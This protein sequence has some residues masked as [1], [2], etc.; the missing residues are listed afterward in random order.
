MKLSKAFIILP[1]FI[2]NLAS[3]SETIADKN[4]SVGSSFEFS[5]EVR[6]EVEK[7]LMQATVFSRKTGKSLAD[8]R[9]SVS[10]NLNQT[11]ESVKQYSTI[12]LESGGIRNVVN[13]SNN[14]KIDGWITEGRIHLKS[15]DFEAMAKV[16]ENLSS[17]MA[18][19][20]IYFSVSPEKIASLEDEMTLEIIKQFQHKADVI[21]K[22]LKLDKY[23]LTNVRLETPN[24][25]ESYFNARP[26]AAMA[27][28]ADSFE[29][30]RLPLEAGKATISARA[31]GQIVF[32]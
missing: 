3:A 23:R 17:E 16:L 11:I 12:Q 29:K 10:K 15:K 5:T 22:G 18:I 24:G 1:L 2:A 30:E 32:E 6:R 26:L 13:Y 7:D 9:K 27:K 4:T 20:D 28:S 14:G 31:T 25:E 19:D 21:Q 8:L